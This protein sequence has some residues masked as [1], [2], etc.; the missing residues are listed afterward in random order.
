MSFF[1]IIM[2]VSG[3]SK[4]MSFWFLHFILPST[5]VDLFL[6][7]DDILKFSHAT[8]GINHLLFLFPR[9][10]MTSTVLFWAAIFLWPVLTGWQGMAAQAYSMKMWVRDVLG[11]IGGVLYTVQPFKITYMHRHVDVWKWLQT[12]VDTIPRRAPDV[13]GLCSTSSP[14]NYCLI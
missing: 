6:G 14:L 1:T 3:T 13:L 12:R 9:Q 10:I 8:D 11:L 4:D 2:F 5:A 7:T